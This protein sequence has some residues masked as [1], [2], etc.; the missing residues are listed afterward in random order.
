MTKLNRAGVERSSN[1]DA[2]A[3]GQCTQCM[4]AI[5]IAAASQDA[6]E[7]GAAQMVEYG[8]EIYLMLGALLR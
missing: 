5:G 6:V 3:L 2:S 7:T 8:T 4:A 1:Q